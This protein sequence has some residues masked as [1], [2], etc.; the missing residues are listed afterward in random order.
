MIDA[1]PECILRRCQSW[2]NSFAYEDEK[3]KDVSRSTRGISVAYRGF[4]T[5]ENRLLRGRHLKTLSMRSI[6]S[7][8]C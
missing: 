3:P 4:N 7:T 6:T 2:H 1:S 8:T 5:E